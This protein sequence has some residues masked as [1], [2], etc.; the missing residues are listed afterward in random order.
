MYVNH[1]LLDAAEARILEVFLDLNQHY[2]AEITKKTKITRPRT[3]RVLRKLADANALTIKKEA[4]VKYYTLN[5]I[6]LTY[7]ALSLVEYNKTSS[8][9][10]KNKTLKRAIALL[11]EK[12]H[13]Y[14]CLLIFGSYAKGNSIKKSDVDLLVVKEDFS[15]KD[16]IELESAAEF[17]AARTGIKLAPYLMKKEELMKKNDFIKEVI[18][19]H[20]IL[21]GSELFLKLVIE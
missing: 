6:P 21:E 10:E 9:L 20:F 11:K 3:L 8:F 7:S 17:A 15:K 5:K 19:N 13:N 1:T 16:V 18:Q 4:N 2:F 14:L 12:Y